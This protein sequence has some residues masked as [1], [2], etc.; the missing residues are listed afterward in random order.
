MTTITCPTHGVVKPVLEWCSVAAN[1]WYRR[2]TLHLG[3]R[4]PECRLWL[5]WLSVFDY[6]A[7]LTPTGPVP[8][9]E[10]A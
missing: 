6:P 7:M 3:A 9:Y 8:A 4:C 10:P 5:G 2:E 1:R